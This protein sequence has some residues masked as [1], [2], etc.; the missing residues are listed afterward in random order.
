[1]RAIAA[2]LVVLAGATSA[3][4]GTGGSERDAKG[5]VGR[6]YAALERRDAAGACEELT[7]EAQSALEREQRKPCEE[8]ILSLELSPS[9]PSNAE[10]AQTSAIVQTQEGDTVFLDQTSAGWRISAAGCVE[11][12][13]SPYE[14]ELES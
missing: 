10:V 4:C 2:A 6:F 11:V 12:P 7:E 1:M 14:C 13:G 5:S 8:A 9:T 3:G